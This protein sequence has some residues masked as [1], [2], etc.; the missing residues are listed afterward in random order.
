LAR[1]AAARRAIAADRQVPVEARPA[2]AGPGVDDVRQA[3]RDF[4]RDFRDV[5]PPQQLHALD[6]VYREFEAAGSRDDR[7]EANAAAPLWAG[8]KW[9]TTA[10][11]VARA[12]R[13]A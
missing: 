6:K 2:P 9:A 11:P 3:Y 10:G 1:L 7:Q 13:G 8:I 5:L 4:I 12:R